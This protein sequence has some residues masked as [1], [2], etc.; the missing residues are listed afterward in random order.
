MAADKLNKDNGLDQ[1]LGNV[2]M[3]IHVKLGGVTHVVQQPMVGCSPNDTLLDLLTF[4][5]IDT[6]TMIV[7]VDVSSVSIYAIRV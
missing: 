2:S 5:Q 6:K 1:Y 4:L 7:G 3:K